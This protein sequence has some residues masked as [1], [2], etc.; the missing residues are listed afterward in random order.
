[1]SQFLA[2]ASLRE[3]IEAVEKQVLCSFLSQSQT[4]KRT[5][6]VPEIVSLVAF[7]AQALGRDVPVNI[8]GGRLQ[9]MKFRKL[10]SCV[11][12]RLSRNS[13]A[14]LLSKSLRRFSALVELLQ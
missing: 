12:L 2:L 9:E 13:I 10:H 11:Q 8:L 4:G 5:F 7:A 1:M 3:D 6:C 14:A